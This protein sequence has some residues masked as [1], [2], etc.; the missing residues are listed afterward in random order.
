MAV[1]NSL[2]QLA[3]VSAKF[4]SV[5]GSSKIETEHL[6][7]GVLSANGTYAQKLLNGFGI[8]KDAKSREKI[9]LSLNNSGTSPA[10][11]LCA[12]PS[13]TEDFPT[14]GSPISTGLFFVFLHKISITRSVSSSR[15]MIFASAF[16]ETFFVKSIPNPF[17]SSGSS[18]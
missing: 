5:L 12:K 4:A 9:I 18:W 13:T 10:F 7:F 3:N 17:K 2:Q 14:P 6:L 8:E 15:P 1:S 16:S 11:I